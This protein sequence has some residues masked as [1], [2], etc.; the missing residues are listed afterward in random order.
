M[1]YKYRNIK[2]NIY[3]NLPNTIVELGPGVGSNMR[4]YKQNTTLLAIEP[5]L[6]MHHLLQKSAQKYK[7]NLEILNLYA[8]K[9]P[10][11][12]STIDTIVC[13]LVLCTVEDPIL[14]LNEIKRVLKPGGKFIFL[15]HVEANKG[16]LLKWIQDKLH[17]P[18]H[19][20][21]EGCNLNRD[22]YNTLIDAGFSNLKIEKLSLKTIFFPIRPHIYGIASK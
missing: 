10:F 7:V 4:Y 9:L 22:T 6:G 19:W 5:N 12:N 13:S 14:V 3:A 1:H 11:A 8:D 16:T 18:W 2:Y 21:F 17:Y 15:E 20:F